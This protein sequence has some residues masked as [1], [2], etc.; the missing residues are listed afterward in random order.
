MDLFLD[1]IAPLVALAVGAAAKSALDWAR[2]RGRSESADASNG[3]LVAVSRRLANLERQGVSR[4]VL[5]EE[6]DAKL[7]RIER[8]QTESVQYLAERQK[9]VEARLTLVEEGLVP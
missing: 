3:E 5:L 4:G 2:N 9:G 8:T 1:Y 6:V 7:D